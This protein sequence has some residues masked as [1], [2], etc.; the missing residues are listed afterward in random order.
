[1]RKAIA[2]SR[3]INY[4]TADKLA[5]RIAATYMGKQVEITGTD[6]GAESSKMLQQM[7]ADYHR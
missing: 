5:E 3:N 4:Q 6:L 2:K 1:M 7:A